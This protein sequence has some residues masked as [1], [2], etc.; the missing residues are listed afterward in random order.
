MKSKQFTFIVLAG[1]LIFCVLAISCSSKSSTGAAGVSGA[2]A[3]REPQ[4][5]R[6]F[7]PQGIEINYTADPLLNSYEDRPRTLL[8]VVYQLNNINAFNKN[9]KDADG[10]AKLLLAESFDQSVVGVDKFF[11]EP[12]EKKTFTTGRAEN[13]RWVG[14]VA[15]YFTLVPDQVNKIFEIPVMSEKK[16]IYGFRKTEVSVLPLKVTLFFGRRSIQLKTEQ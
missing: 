2:Q 16:G 1:C 14:I 3:S 10:L 12:G 4:P 9:V 13:T 7:D 8:A 15:G 5:E 6:F 11:I